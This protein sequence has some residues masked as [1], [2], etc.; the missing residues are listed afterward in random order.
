MLCVAA[1]EMRGV[2]R[3]ARSLFIVPSS[4]RLSAWLPFSVRTTVA[5]GMQHLRPY[6]LGLLKVVSLHYALS[7]FHWFMAGFCTQHWRAEI[8]AYLSWRYL[9]L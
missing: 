2:K 9:T 8:L 6:V 1:A 7:V 4:A 3:N 5:N